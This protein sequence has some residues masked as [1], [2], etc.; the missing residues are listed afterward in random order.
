MHLAQLLG[1]QKPALAKAG[2]GPKSQYCSRMIAMALFGIS[3]GLRR[4]LARPR[5]IESNP[6]AP[7]LRYAF[8][9]LEHLAPLEPQQLRCPLNRQ[10]S[11]I[12]IPAAPR[13]A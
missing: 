2:V 13:A 1:R 9:K 3:S 8:T 6:V 5:R 10:P 12:Q 11:L 4:L 7:S